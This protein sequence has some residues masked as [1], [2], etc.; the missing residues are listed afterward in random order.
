M[1][2]LRRGFYAALPH[3]L[4]S[5]LGAFAARLRGGPLSQSF[6]HW[7][8]RH[9]DVNLGEAAEP[10]P[11]AYASF[12]SFFTRALADGARPQPPRT[13]AVASP[14]DGVVSACGAIHDGMVLQAKGIDYS[15]TQLLDSAEAAARYRHGRF[16]T[17]YL[18]PCDYHRVHAPITGT[19]RHIRHI[20]GRLWPVR[21]WAVAGVEGLFARNERAVLEFATSSGPYALVMVG[22]LMVGGLETRLTGPIRGG[23]GRPSDWNLDATETTLE[24]GEEVGRFNFG[25]TVI[26]LFP[27]NK[28][29]LDGE[30]ETGREL[31]LGQPI[32]VRAPEPDPTES[33]GDPP[34]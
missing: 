23:R 16:V 10:D 19:L 26:L 24:R 27:E 12:A 9:Y 20:G 14:V 7:F 17:L 33:P 25:S 18:R 2:S 30:L 3:H 11:D 6:I 1:P 15:V 21:P 13:D 28:V 4:L 5:R 8:V 22:A 32:G 34:R 31:R 29:K